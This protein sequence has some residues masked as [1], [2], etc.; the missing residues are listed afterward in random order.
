MSETLT[1]NEVA[2]AGLAQWEFV[3]GAIH[4]TFQTKDFASA[5]S[6]VNAIGDLAEQHNHH[7]DLELGWGKVVVHFTSHDVGGVTD[8]DVRLAQL[9]DGLD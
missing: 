2:E 1:A 5:L 6:K 3:D 4:R 8:R 9:V 7:P